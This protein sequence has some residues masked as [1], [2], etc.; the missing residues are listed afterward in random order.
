MMSSTTAVEIK[1]NYSGSGRYDGLPEHTFTMLMEDATD[2]SSDS[3]FL[4]FERVLGALGYCETAIMSGA[5]SLAF[6]E[7]RDPAEMKKVAI[8]HDLRLIEDPDPTPTVRLEPIKN[9]DN[10]SLYELIRYP[11]DLYES[12][13]P[14]KLA[15][16]L[17][18]IADQ[19]QISGE[20]QYG[21]Y[22][23]T[24]EDVREWLYK[25]AEK[26]DTAWEPKNEPERQP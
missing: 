18:R 26:A 7:L 6:N 3:W 17:R 1:I 9:P 11:S 25:E 12:S 14:L 20:D 23:T 5:C 13:W 22:Q 16:I 19:I 2:L 8:E 10:K 15:S 21:V 4:L 24:G